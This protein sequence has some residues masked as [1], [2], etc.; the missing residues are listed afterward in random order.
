MK[1]VQDIKDMRSASAYHLVHPHVNQM[2]KWP[3]RC[4]TA[5]LDIS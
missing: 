4:T 2:A 5:D 3:L 1:L